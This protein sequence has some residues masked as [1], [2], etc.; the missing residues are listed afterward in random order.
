MKN[1]RNGAYRGG[2]ADHKKFRENRP[3]ESENGE[4]IIYG[5]NAVI[6]ALRAKVPINRIL[7]AGEKNGSVNVIIALAKE[8]GVVFASASKE[9]ISELTGT[10]NHQG[11]AACLAAAE[12][13]DIDD[14]LKIAEERGE[15]PFVIILDEIQDAHNLGAVIRTADAVGAHGVI[16]PKRRAASL[17]GV[18]AKTSAGAVSHV[19]VA[20]VPNIPAAIE[21]L[22][23]NGL[24]IAGT[25]L[26][27]DTR[28][29]DADFKGPIGIVIGSEG[30][31]MGR[32]V[33]ESCDFILT[34]PMRGMVS[35]LNASVA[36]GVVL[37]EVFRQ[38]NGRIK[39]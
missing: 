32:L 10:E 35:S 26:D 20:R 19:A 17:T 21:T 39:E 11:V 29:Y 18:V 22:K 34:I 5:R 2:S 15:P 24:W 28:F 16:I 38:R 25:D 12:Y 37:Y 30:N 6:E 36:A 9:K 27:G 33:R 1:D 31:G 4:T 14:I 3:E 8:N 7:I 13:C 23:K